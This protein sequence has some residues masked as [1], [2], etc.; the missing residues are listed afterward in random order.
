MKAGPKRSLDLG[1]RIAEQR[2]AVGMKVNQ[3]AELVGVSRNTIT[4]WEAGRTEVN[5]SDLLK[6]S[7]ALGCDFMELLG[8]L[9]MTPP[10]R[11]AFR[12][13]KRLREDP[14]LLAT[15]R[16]LCY[17]YLDIEEIAGK[18][19]TNVLPRHPFNPEKVDWEEY[20]EGIADLV[21]ER[22]KFHEM[23]PGRIP[24]TLESVGVRCLF[25][26]TEGE[27]LDGISTVFQSMPLILLRTRETGIER[28]IFSAAH[29]LGH[30]VLHPHLF[31]EEPGDNEDGRDY[32]R[33]ANHFAGC[34]LVPKCDLLRVWDE[35]SLE[36]LSTLHALM[37]LKSVF[38]VS[39]HCLFHRT[40]KLGLCKREYPAFIAELK[41]L[42][43]I[44]GKA[45][46]SDLE[47]APL[48]PETLQRTT[49]FER[50]VRSAY[51]QEEISVAKVAEM[52]QI[53]VEDAVK[54]TY[55]WVKPDVALVA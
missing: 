17:A 23:G 54:L 36:G 39:I 9:P 8:V 10:P 34:F 24:E 43:G 32:E 55:K 35:Y 40:K 47:P 31:V 13:H 20:V 28:T 53:P 7:R 15:A 42:L 1:G 49:R 11:F 18:R 16:R 4:N 48:A 21:R 51:L 6:I 29:E 12:A 30:L 3:L 38:E 25:F 52:F 22:C 45:N 2:K 27:G 5:A 37:I 46:M 44:K 19:L 14:E 33:E 26:S 41:S 50:L